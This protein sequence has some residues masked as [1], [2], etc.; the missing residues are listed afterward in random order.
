MH[1]ARMIDIHVRRASAISVLVSVLILLVKF[2]AFA[3]THSQAIF[4][5]AM[6]SVVNV[7]GAVVAVV[8]LAYARRPA[9]VDHPYG[10]GKI[11][12]FSAA[13]EGG[14]IA[15]A[16]VMIWVEALRSLVNGVAIHSL[17]L[18]LLITVG[19]GLANAALGVYL[20]Y[21]AK[22]HHSSALE[23]SGAHVLADSLTSVGVVVGLG[24][25]MWT[26][27]SWFDS[28]AALL[29]GSLLAYTGLRLV[30]RSAGGLLDAED[31]QLLANLAN[32]YS[33][34]RLSG[35]I[36]LHH[37]RVMRSGHYHHID[38]HVV[39]P[40]FWDVSEAHQHTEKF[41]AEMMRD[42]AFPGELHFH[43]DPCRRAYCR[44]CDAEACPIRQAPFEK[45]RQLSLEEMV[46]PE[47]PEQFR[48]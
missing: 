38:A 7:I 43:V 32:I 11:E 16:A 31:R 21:V 44:H 37:V 14:L 18:G 33:R 20:K 29:M 46:N 8:V 22:K 2:W 12:F 17:G 25:A 40:E 15:F 28:L 26:G 19:T 41:E 24:L 13:F 35:I 10:H 45:L 36:Q 39:V 9:D 47:E 27:V 5:D 3:A 42:Y 48:A 6:E 4:S 23:A 1:P 34:R 30:L